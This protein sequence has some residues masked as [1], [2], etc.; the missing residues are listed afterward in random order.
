MSLL[1]H[2]L[3]YSV[4]LTFT[5]FF[6]CYCWDGVLF[7][8]LH[9]EAL[10]V[11][12]AKCLNGSTMLFLSTIG[13]YLVLTLFHTYRWTFPDKTSIPVCVAKLKLR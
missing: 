10:Y 4:S 1:L 8:V 6:G 5:F 9:L 11:S 7:S 2:H 3:L 13:G 12:I